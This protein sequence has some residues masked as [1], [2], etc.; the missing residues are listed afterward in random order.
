MINFSEVENIPVT[1]LKPHVDNSRF[2]SHLSEHLY[3]ELKEDIRHKGIVNPLLI[4]ENF[5]IISGHNRW[6]IAKELD[7]PTVP[8]LKVVGTEEELKVLMIS[9]NSLR[10]SKE[11]NILCLV[12][13]ANEL[14]QFE[15]VSIREGAC[16]MGI[17]KSA[18]ERLILLGKLNE[19]FLYLLRDGTLTKSAAYL[20]AKMTSQTQRKYYESLQMHEK[21]KETDVKALDLTKEDADKKYWSELKIKIV[22]NNKKYFAELSRLLTQCNTKG[23]T[24]EMKDFLMHLQQQLASLDNGEGEYN[25]D[26]KA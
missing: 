4:S 26:T 22:K 11:N 12:D 2:F 9:D 25:H 8:C 16:A 1:L 14:S 10:R 23:V 15:T 20:L 6:R 5:I 7:L 17:S 3:S 18:F 24:D 21:I 19:E 13:Q